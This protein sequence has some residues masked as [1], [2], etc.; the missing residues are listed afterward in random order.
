[1]QQVIQ[2]ATSLM[3]GLDCPRSLSVAIM[4]RYNDLKQV[5]S[6]DCLPSDYSSPLEY[7]RAAAATA[8]LKKYVCGEPSKEASE[9]TFHKWL[10]AEK[11]C[12]KTNRRFFEI[13]D[14]GTSRGALVDDVQLHFL[15]RMRKNLSEMLGA[16]PEWVKP[17]FGPG[18]T[19]S[20]RHGKTVMPHKMSSQ[21]TLTPSA[22]GI[23]PMW[24]QTRWADVV[25]DLEE[26]R[27]NV[28]F[29]VPKTADILRPCAKEPSINGS[30]QLGVGEL[31][32]KRLKAAGI[33]LST[34][35]E[36]HMRIAMQA[37]LTGSHATIDLSSASDT[38]A[39]ALVKAVLPSDWFDILNQ[40]RSHNTRVNG[41]WY[42]LEK[43]SSMGNGFT[44]PLETA[45]FAACVK[46][47]HPDLV[48]GSDFFVFGDDIIV[49]TERASS[50]VAALKWL[51]FIPNP[52][53][54]FLEGPFRESCGGD[55]WLGHDVR[56]V[57]LES[58]PKEPHE[59]ISAANALRTLIDRLVSLGH[60]RGSLIRTWIC[61]VGYLPTS[62]SRARGPKALGDVVI[63]DDERTWKFKYDKHSQIRYILTYNSRP[64]RGT[65]VR[66][67]R[68]GDATLSACYT[69]SPGFL[70]GQ[71]PC[72]Q[73]AE[74]PD[75]R[76]IL[77][78]IHI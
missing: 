19:M 61:C 17:S 11:L 47:L 42:R 60:N 76:E 59:Y 27:G 8:Y 29:T 6:L 24:S 21:P 14:Y 65:G 63:H 71:D 18:A 51:G 64:R 20:D 50:V 66:I 56:P 75:E 70:A 5:Q 31:M 28:Y 54:T 39:L 43:F 57:Y 58:T 37:S 33:D 48:L 4:L 13:I 67:C 55:Y 72:W 38:V 15:K 74:T 46:S 2:L 40:L 26:V 73:D 23:L 41:R 35:K 77:S 9:A 30:Y 52:K 78:L 25:T 32:S 44:F 22:F 3:T 62:I 16:P 36:L 45:I 1:M 49:P 34:G 7:L 68:F 12:F 69:H 53:K 10:E